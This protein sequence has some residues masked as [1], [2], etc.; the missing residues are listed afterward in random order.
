MSFIVKHLGVFAIIA[1]QNGHMGILTLIIQTILMHKNDHFIIPIWNKLLYFAIAN[2]DKQMVEWMIILGA[3]NISLKIS[4]VEIPCQ[5]FNNIIN[6][7][8][9][10]NVQNNCCNK[11]IITYDVK[12]FASH[13]NKY[14]KNPKWHSDITDWEDSIGDIYN[15]SFSCDHLDSN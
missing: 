7:I 12:Y 14:I 2:N 15:N 13:K 1:Y 8:I 9:D 11:N 4:A 5:I 3:S 10:H 6:L